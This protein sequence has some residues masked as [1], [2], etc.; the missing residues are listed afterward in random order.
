MLADRGHARLFFDLMAKSWPRP[1][2]RGGDHARVSSKTESSSRD[3]R[4]T[5]MKASML[6]DL[7]RGNRIEL[8]WLAGK[9][10]SLGRELGVPTPANEA[11]YKMLKLSRM[12]G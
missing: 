6:H 1:R 3:A 12:G 8:D 5:T 10:V 7:E 4:R 11:V 2:Q 9:V